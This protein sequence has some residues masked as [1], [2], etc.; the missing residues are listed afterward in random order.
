MVGRGHGEWG[1]MCQLGSFISEKRGFDARNGV[2][3]RS[4]M[5]REL[6]KLMVEFGSAAF[7]YLAAGF[8]KHGV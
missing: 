7:G 8:C 6:G 1:S 2:F 4:L 3:A 5:M